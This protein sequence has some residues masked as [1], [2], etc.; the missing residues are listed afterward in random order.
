MTE[1]SRGRVARR[2]AENTVMGNGHVINGLRGNLQ[3]AEVTMPRET[4]LERGAG[5]D[6]YVNGVK[7]R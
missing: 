1:R 2:A 4:R 5:E 6:C 3:K 7:Q